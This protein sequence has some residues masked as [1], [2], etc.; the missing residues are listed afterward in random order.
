MPTMRCLARHCDYL[1]AQQTRWYLPTWRNRRRL[2]W[3]SLQEPCFGCCSGPLVLVGEPRLQYALACRCQ[4]GAMSARAVFTAVGAIP[5]RETSDAQG[6]S[7][8]PVSTTQRSLRCLA[9]AVLPLLP[10]ALLAAAVG[11]PAPGRG[12]P[13]EPTETLH[14]RVVARWTGWLEERSRRTYRGVR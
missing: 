2:L 3:A 6:L 14:V 4:A 9:R 12:K 7:L 10:L 11:A 8:F 1:R 13:P 5:G